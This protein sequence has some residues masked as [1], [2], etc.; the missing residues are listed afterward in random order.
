MTELRGL[1]QKAD[2]LAKLG[3]K[4]VAIS[5]DDQGHAHEVWEKV[6]GK[7]FTVLSDP[8][9]QVIRKYGLLHAAGR[10]SDD[11][12]L[13]TTLLIDPRGLEKWRRVSESIPDIPTVEETVSRIKQAQGESSGLDKQ[14]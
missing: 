5:V 13:R 10:G 4:V 7:K 6:A 9:A 11:I 14:H 1:A 2:E 8:G 3:V 12:A